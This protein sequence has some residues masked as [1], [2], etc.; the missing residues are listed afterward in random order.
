M[1][2][3]S[4]NFVDELLNPS[5]L[6][7]QRNLLMEIIGRVF[8]DI[9]QTGDETLLANFPFRKPAEVRDQLIEEVDRQYTFVL[10]TYIESRFRVDFAQRIETKNKADRRKL[11][12]VYKEI[13]K[14]L[15]NNYPDLQLYEVSLKDV[16]I[17]NWRDYRPARRKE[18]DYLNLYLEELP[19]RNWMAHG[20]YW[21]LVGA[22][23][24]KYDFEFI[25]MIVEGIEAKIGSELM[26]LKADKRKKRK[27]NPEL[28]LFSK[29]P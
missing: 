9:K 7:S 12:T 2:N 27:G 23:S 24:H 26:G 19:Y 17:K 20:R 29:I 13:F 5:V 15:K 4:D 14:E 6:I 22:D 25:S 8:K 16:M 10:L 3:Y 1:A 18:R 28:D 11:T 21:K